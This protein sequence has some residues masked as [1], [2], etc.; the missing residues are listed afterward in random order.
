LL[1]FMSAIRNRNKIPITK[2]TSASRS[3][4]HTLLYLDT[5]I[6]PFVDPDIYSIYHPIIAKLRTRGHK[7]PQFRKESHARQ[8]KLVEG[9]EDIK[10]LH[11]DCAKV[12]NKRYEGKNPQFHLPVFGEGEKRRM[13]YR[14]RMRRC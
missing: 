6:K 5:Y 4:S 8:R 9:D 3:M 12:H 13:R 7:D 14:E 10:Q 2:V 11:N 1:F